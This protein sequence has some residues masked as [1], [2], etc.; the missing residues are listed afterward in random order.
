MY[1]FKPFHRIAEAHY[2]RVNIT[3]N[4]SD[5]SRLLPHLNAV[6]FLLTAEALT[7][8]ENTDLRLFLQDMFSYFFALAA[9]SH[10]YNIRVGSNAFINSNCTILDTCTV[11]IGSRTLVGPSVSF[12]SGTH[13]M[14]GSSSTGQD[15]WIAGKVIVLPGVTVGGGCT[16]GARTGNPARIL[17]KIKRASAEDTGRE[18]T[19]QDHKME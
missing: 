6:A 18:D 10:G 17:R 15:C 11:S 13:I 5:V 4:L 16:I 14:G 9:F 7:P 2:P 3:Q 8:S 1:S 12:F 19:G